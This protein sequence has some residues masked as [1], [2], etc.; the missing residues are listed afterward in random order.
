MDKRQ[1]CI[2][3]YFWRWTYFP[4]DC[5]MD[6]RQHCIVDYFWRWT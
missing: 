1:H 6:K 3:D 4:H 5:T 2:V